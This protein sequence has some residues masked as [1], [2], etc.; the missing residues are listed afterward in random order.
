ME[1]GIEDGE[2]RRKEQEFPSSTKAEREEYLRNWAMNQRHPVTREAKAELKRRF[3][4]GIGTDDYS[5]ILREVD[6]RKTEMESPVVQNQLDDVVR[7]GRA[8]AAAG[9][10]SLKVTKDGTVLAFERFDK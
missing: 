5:R 6:R 4:I 7:L 3:G 10:A 9:I 1:P 2:G 8:M